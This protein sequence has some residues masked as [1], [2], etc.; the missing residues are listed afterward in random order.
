M[1]VMFLESTTDM[2]VMHSVPIYSLYWDGLVSNE[3]GAYMKE[4]YPD[5]V[6]WYGAVDI[7]EPFEQIKAKVD[8]L[9]NQGTDGIKLY[10]TRL[11]PT[12]KAP[13]QFMMDD[14]KRGFPVY[15]YIRIK[16]IRHIATHKLVGYSGPETAALGVNDYYRAAEAFPDLIFH[17]VHGGWL[18]MEE[19]AALMKARE[20]VTA[21]L[22]GPMLW[23]LYDMAN[24]HKMMAI[25]MNSVDVDRIIYASTS[26]NQHPYWIVNNFIDY[27]PPKGAGWTLSDADKRK[28][29]GE[30][31]ARYHG[32]DI[33]AQRAKIA[34]DRFSAYV[35]RNGLREPY[36][37]QRTGA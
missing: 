16:G 3:K 5:R 36:L 20:N 23:T 26:P 8:Q 2:I 22:E 31:L 33:K 10:P 7:F 14:E 18:L 13:E 24:F 37:V 15:D 21:V 11:N 9:V 32:I 29:L 30:N 27:V 17:C 6:L 4:R 1:D 12:T 28:I 25:F 35:A 19:T 34:K